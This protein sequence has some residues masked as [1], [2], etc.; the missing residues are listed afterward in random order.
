VLYAFGLVKFAPAV[1][2]TNIL[3]EDFMQEDPKRKKTGNM[4]S[5]FALLGSAR[6]K[7]VRKMLVNWLQDNF[8]HNS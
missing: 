1:N 7:A 5:L 2:F 4:T 6:L 3:Q 8:C